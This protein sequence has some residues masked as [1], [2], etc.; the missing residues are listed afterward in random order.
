MATDRRAAAILAA[1]LAT[2]SPAAVFAQQEPMSAID[3]LSQSVM[4]PK[5]A[6]LSPKDPPAAGTRVPASKPVINEAPIAKNG[7]PADVTTSVL[8]APSPDG[9]GLLSAA[10]T[11]LPRA[12]WGMGRTEDIARLVTQERV[13]TLPALQGLMLTLLL[14]E[15]DPPADSGGKGV[16]L[17]ARI[18]KLL[19]MGALDQAQALIEASGVTSPEL[20]RRKFDVA[21][22]TGTEDA[23][24][25]QMQALPNLAPTLPAR[26]F[27][28]ARAGDWNAAA[29][30]LRTAQALGNVSEAEDTLLSRF[31]DPD[32]YE[33][34]GPLPI[35]DR[36]TP[37]IWR[38]FEA[39]GE[40][41]PT[42]SL[43]VAFA[44]AEL[45][46]QAGWK[47]Q[48]E[49]AER[50]ARVGAIT[51]N[52]LLGIYTERLPAASGGVWDRVD[53]FQDFDAALLAG[54]AETVANT[55]PVVWS[56]MVEAELEVP[57][58]RLYGEA[59]MKLPLEGAASALA[60]RIGLLSPVYEQVANA[61]KPADATEAFLIGLARGN[62]AGTEAQ[63]SMA[64]AIAPA[65]LAPAPLPEAMDLLKDN[66]MG[67]ALLLAIDRIGRGVQGEPRG[68]AEG[69]ALLRH[70]KLESIAR[71]TAL[72]LL[73][74]ERRG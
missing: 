20:F 8:G 36:P 15:A 47:S 28:L 42:S 25:D 26:I 43:P 69:L 7:L 54:N 10:R 57:F 70:V 6:T 51:P 2:V 17:M 3:W 24:C 5:G 73:L 49:A 9:V 1:L 67:E 27:C 33:D 71:R 45:R 16:L 55:L 65:F 46:D 40:P 22:L 23:A 30:T 19:A 60:F 58:A 72:E 32:R 56:R 11:G 74:L 37:L 48:V 35:P 13:D 18:D 39:L 41:L 64:R 53:A 52:L 44:H 66:R 38:M 61:R 34:E 50:L 4:T 12:L 21:L 14:A 29:L 63:D 68:V 62:L 59:L 31:L